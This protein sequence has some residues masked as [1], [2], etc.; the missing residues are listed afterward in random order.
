VARDLH[1]VSREIL[2]WLAHPPY[3]SDGRSSRS[4]LRDEIAFWPLR[5]LERLSH[6]RFIG[7]LI[8]V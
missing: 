8:A 7:S 3:R 1:A 2:N 5:D 6:Q 4:N